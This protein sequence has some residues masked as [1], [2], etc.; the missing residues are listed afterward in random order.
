MAILF[1]LVILAVCIVAEI[2]TNAFIALFIGFGAAVA[3]IMAFAGTVF[4]VQ[5]VVWLALSVVTLF[6]LRPFAMKNFHRPLITDLSSPAKSALTNL[7]G[8][9]EST[10]GDE[11]HPGRVRIQGESWKAVTDWL[12]PIPD[13]SA[14]VVRKTYG[15]TLWVDPV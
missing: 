5:T 1:W 11:N 8:V 13:G 12:E 2:H 10:V 4:V 3:L 15:T 7:R 14:I 6:A 9:V